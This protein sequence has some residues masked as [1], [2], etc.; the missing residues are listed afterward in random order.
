MTHKK[1]KIS[2][3]LCV[4]ILTVNVWS[5]NTDVGLSVRQEIKT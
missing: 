4:A 5:A 2:L 1:I 3:G